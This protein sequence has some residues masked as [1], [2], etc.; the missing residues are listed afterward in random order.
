MDNTARL[1]ANRWYHLYFGVMLAISLAVIAGYFLTKSLDNLHSWQNT[2]GLGEAILALV[3]AQIIYAVSLYWLVRSK[4]QP[5]AL[6]VCSMLSALVILYGLGHSGGV[7]AWIFAAVWFLSLMFVGMYGLMMAVAGFMLAAVFVMTQTNLILANFTPFYLA[8][9]L[10]SGL[11]ALLG[12]LFWRTRFINPADQQVSRLSGMLRSKQEQSAIL[13]ESLTDGVIVVDNE[14]KINLINPAA[15]AMTGWS[16]EDARGVDAR[17]VAKLSQQNGQ[18]IESEENPLTTVI[19]Q[20]QPKSQTLQLTGRDGKK[21]VVSLAISPVVV[22]GTM[23]GAVAVVRDISQQFAAEQQRA[24]FISTASHEMR[25]PVAAIEGYLAL[26]LSPK[27]ST[28]DSR[29]KNYLEKAH[30]STQHLGKLFQDLLTSAKAEDG[31]LS[32]HPT[33]VEMGSFLEQLVEDFK[34]TAQKKSLITDFAVG[35]T[36]TIDAT[37]TDSSLKVI[38]PLYYVYA[39]PER[40]REVLTNLFDNAVKYTEQGKITLGLTGDNEVVQIYVR[41]TGQGIP[42]DDI[43]HLFQKFYRVDSSATRVVGGT[44]LGLFIARKIIELYR[45]RMWVESELDKGST[46]YINLPRLTT[47][48]AEQL[49]SA[50]TVLQNTPQPAAK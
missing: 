12:Y 46:F 49:Q 23:T 22:N 17:L 37:N 26:A 14:F 5:L 34:V 25:T 28:I 31:R 29:A 40:L 32:S 45:G 50:E 13:L 16:I 33:V 43:P 18:E 35:E 38:K 7:G 30:T 36:Q 4:R 10:G 1:V 42:A 21:R 47:R 15:A 20:Q 2:F 48:R 27:V 6:T 8:V 9:L 24:E 11:A 19:K 3:A 41:D 39:D 44:G